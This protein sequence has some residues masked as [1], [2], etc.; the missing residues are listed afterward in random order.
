MGGSAYNFIRETIP[1]PS[2]QVLTSIL[3]KIPIESG[4]SSFIIDHMTQFAKVIPNIEKICI[5][6]FD[7]VEIKS[8]VEMKGKNC[9]V[10]GIVD[11]GHSKNNEFC[12]HA[13][14]FQLR[15][16]NSG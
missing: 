6:M 15:G 1:M 4:L 14:V 7:E 2:K 8:R 9:T 5:L 10:Y 16:L 13:L 3:D 11:N 12:N